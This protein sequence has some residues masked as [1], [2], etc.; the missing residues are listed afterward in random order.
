MI[1]DTEYLLFIGLDI[2]TTAPSTGTPATMVTPAT[3]SNSTNS[4][5]APNTTTTIPTTTT[6]TTNKSTTAAATTT[7]TA[8]AT[9]STKVTTKIPTSTVHNMATT[10]APRSG[11][12]GGSFVGGMILASGKKMTLSSYLSQTSQRSC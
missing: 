9:T 11:F 8:A 5:S 3:V 7:T 2:N 1:G 6:T 10:P 12:D 4:T